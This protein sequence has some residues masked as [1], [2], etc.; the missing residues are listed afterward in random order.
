MKLR[1]R[2]R[3]SG[4]A[5]VETTVVS[6]FLV[7]LLL[8]VIGFGTILQASIRLETAAREGARIATSGGTNDDVRREILHNLSRTGSESDVPGA[9]A[10]GISPN[11]LADRV[12]NQEVSIEV[13]WRY[14]VPVALFNLLVKERELYA[15]KRMVVTVGR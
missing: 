10:I 9:V 3:R 13:W 15:R 1:F 8:G 2:T 4:Q 6:M 14:P 11:N 5:F 12:F 7:I